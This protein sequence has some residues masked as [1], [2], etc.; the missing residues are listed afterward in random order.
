L[1]EPILNLHKLSL[2]QKNNLMSAIEEQGYDDMM[3]VPQALGIIADANSKWSTL[4][5]GELKA[6]LALSIK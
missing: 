1:R 6:M 3:L 4:R 2:E 5:F